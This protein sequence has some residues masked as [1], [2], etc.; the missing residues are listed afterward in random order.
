[1]LSACLLHSYL[2]IISNVLGW[3]EKSEILATVFF[4]EREGQG[5]RERVGEE[6]REWR[7]EGGV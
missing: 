1:M 4:L 7:R 5:R 6:E 3:K 2:R